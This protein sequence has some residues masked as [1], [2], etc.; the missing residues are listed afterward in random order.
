V[1]LSL[2]YST[3]GEFGAASLLVAVDD[4]RRA[5]MQAVDLGAGLREMSSGACRA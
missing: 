5:S 1:E 4:L 2:A 3:Y